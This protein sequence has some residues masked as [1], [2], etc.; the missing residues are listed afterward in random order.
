MGFLGL[1][2]KKAP[3]GWGWFGVCWVNY[4]RAFVAIT[5]LAKTT[6]MDRKTALIE[7]TQKNMRGDF[8]GM[9]LIL[10]WLGKCNLL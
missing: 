8:R 1:R 6:A 4:F 9:G 5:M 3:I 7:K 10:R 2:A